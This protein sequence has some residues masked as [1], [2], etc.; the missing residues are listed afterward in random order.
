MTGGASVVRLSQNGQPRGDAYHAQLVAGFL[1][2]GFSAAWLGRRQKNAIG[3]T[4]NVFFRAEDADVG[5]DFV[6]VG[7]DVVVA[8]R[9]VIAH[10]I[11][12]PD[13]EIH[14]GHAQGDASPV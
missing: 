9:P 14:R 1:D 10:A 2:D 7:R 4:G 3:R 5:F 13:F 6:V 12:R 8:Q 11:V